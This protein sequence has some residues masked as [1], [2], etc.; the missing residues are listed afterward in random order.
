[1]WGAGLGTFALCFV[2]AMLRVY[3]PTHSL[4]YVLLRGEGLEPLRAA[5][6]VRLI[7]GGELALWA[8]YIGTG[9]MA[10]AAIYPVW[11]R[12]RFFRRFASNTMWFDFHL[13]TGIVGPLFIILHSTLKL[14]TWVSSAFWSMTIVVVSGVVG[15]YLY[16]KVPDLL[17]GR[18][19]EELD[20]QRAF[21][22]I[23][24]LH[25]HAV[26]EVEGELGVHREK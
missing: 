10:I 11:R 21:A 26:N 16:T 22:S 18:E 13:M 24:K 7:P 25:A 20:H 15:R 14:D 5:E 3:A 8:G 12:I 4:Q 6:A 19:L 2:E 23:R 17:N 1:M 9:M